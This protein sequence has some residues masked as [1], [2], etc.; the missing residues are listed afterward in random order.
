MTSPE[1]S[2]Q[3]RQD[4]RSAHYA[5]NSLTLIGAVSMG[6]GVMIGAGIFALTGQIAELLDLRRRKRGHHR[7]GR[8][9][10]VQPLETDDDDGLVDLLDFLF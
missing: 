1:N 4:D 8:G 2:G 3:S 9:Q 5:K 10:I 6:T 7:H